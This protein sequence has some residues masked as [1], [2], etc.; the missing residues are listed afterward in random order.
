MKLI[1]T[2]SQLKRILNEIGGYDD[3]DI[4]NVHASSVQSPLLQTIASTVN[5]LNSFIG[6]TSYGNPTIESIKNYLDKLILKLS[7]DVNLISQLEDEIYIDEDFKGS[8]DAYKRTLISLQNKLRILYSDGLGM[9]HDM[10]K[11]EVISTIMQ[12]LEDLEPMINRMTKMFEVIH[13]RY[14]SRLGFN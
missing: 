3:R 8:I 1:I 12:Y 7:M 11:E 6:M 10:S 4:M 5:M 13:G 2:E 9:I 14:R